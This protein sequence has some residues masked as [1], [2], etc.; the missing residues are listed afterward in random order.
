[1]LGSSRM[2]E[3]G[4]LPGQAT[5]TDTNTAH[6]RRVFGLSG[7]GEPANSS[8]KPDLELFFSCD[9]THKEKKERFFQHDL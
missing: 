9:S 6:S 2:L 1:M 8:Q 7:L 5:R 4:I 3:P